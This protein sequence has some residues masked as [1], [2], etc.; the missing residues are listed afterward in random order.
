MGVTYTGPMGCSDRGNGGS[1]VNY[2]EQ[3][4]LRWLGEANPPTP[5]KQKGTV[6]LSDGISAD[7]KAPRLR[8]EIERLSNTLD[9]LSNQNRAIATALD[10][11]TGTI[12]T[13]EESDKPIVPVG[14]DFT[15][16]LCNVATRLMRETE[17]TQQSAKRLVEL[18]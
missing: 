11:L 1:S 14:E 15:S 18:I 2:T 5:L 3:R 9:D 10:R 7:R 13:N 16:Q 4:L 17:K 8:A 6:M 12:A